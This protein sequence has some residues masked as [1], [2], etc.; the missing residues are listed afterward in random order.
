MESERD[1]DCRTLT[2]LETCNVLAS[3]GLFLRVLQILAECMAWLRHC[4]AGGGSGSSQTSNPA[5]GQ[6]FMLSDLK[7]GALNAGIMLVGMIAAGV[8]PLA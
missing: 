7:T 6:A 8:W 3:T 1:A 2:G 5:V 4:S